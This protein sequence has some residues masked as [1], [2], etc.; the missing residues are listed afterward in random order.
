MNGELVT[1][2]QV[3]VVPSVNHDSPVQHLGSNF[4]ML[5]EAFANLGVREAFSHAKVHTRVIA[6]VNCFVGDRLRELIIR[7]AVISKCTN[8]ILHIL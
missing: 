5:A 3:F 2:G 1:D 4:N 7:L 6:R 8:C